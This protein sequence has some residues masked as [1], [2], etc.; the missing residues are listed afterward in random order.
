MTIPCG[1]IRCNVAMEYK[2]LFNNSSYLID[3]YGN[4]MHKKTKKKLKVLGANTPIIYIR[5]KCYRVEELV[6]KTFLGDYDTEKMMVV[7]IDGNI[8]NNHHT[9]LKVEPRLKNLVYKPIEGFDKYLVSECGDV[10]SLITKKHMAPVEDLDGYYKVTLSNN[11]KCT[12]FFV[13]RLVASAFCE[14]KE[15]CDVVNHIDSNRKNNH[16]SNLEWTTPFG[17]LHHGIEHGYVKLYGEDNPNSKLTACDVERIRDMY[18]NGISVAE[19]QRKYNIVTW[20]SI[21]NI[22]ARRTFK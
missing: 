4:V 9:N 7:H 5:S 16:Y 17:N 3:E 21:K 15:G 6:A 18:E 10:Y 22:V 11:K 14:K 13:H 1:G 19:I 20:E 12:T 2:K 8:K